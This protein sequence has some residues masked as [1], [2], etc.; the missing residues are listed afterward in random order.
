MYSY[1]KSKYVFKGYFENNG[2]MFIV[3]LQTVNYKKKK[4]NE[5]CR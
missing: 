1:I 2:K 5:Y 3:L 4:R